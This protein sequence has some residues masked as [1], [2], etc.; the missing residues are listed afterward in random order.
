MELAKPVL[1]M[2][3]VNELVLQLDASQR[4]MEHTVMNHFISMRL[5]M[6]EIEAQNFFG[7]FQNKYENR[8]EK[9]VYKRK[10]GGEE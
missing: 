6:D 3:T 7:R 1:D 4:V 8:K 2:E 9:F 10:N 5:E